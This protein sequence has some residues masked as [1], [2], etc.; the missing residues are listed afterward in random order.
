MHESLTKT[1][2]R[3]LMTDVMFC[4]AMLLIELLKPVMGM[5]LPFSGKKMGVVKGHQALS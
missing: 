5:G 4:L 2:L 3:N 1:V